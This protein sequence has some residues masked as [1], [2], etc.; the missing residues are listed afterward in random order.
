MIKHPKLT[1]H[2]RHRPQNP[3]E[4]KKV[5]FTT[6]PSSAISAIKKYPSGTNIFVL[7]SEI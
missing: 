7:Y 3:K 6:A 5:S 1:F 4:R 2:I